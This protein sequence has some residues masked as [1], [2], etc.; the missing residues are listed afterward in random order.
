MKKNILRVVV[1][2]L[3]IGTFY[4][5]FG[6]SGQ[7]GDQSGALS[8]QITEYIAKNIKTIQNMNND[9]KEKV[10]KK[11][12]YYVR[13]LAHFSLYAIVGILIMT[14]LFTYKL[15]QRTRIISCLT[16]GTIYAI[17]DE[18]HQS[19]IPGRTPMVGDVM[20][21]MCGVLAGIVIVSFIWKINK[22]AKK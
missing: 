12:E 4:I 20:I 6:F 1:F 15:R 16:I 5:I 17:S 13:K 21:D 7:N 22:L 9:Q 2:I 3:L 18:I 19:F 10:L 14:L 11:M 8:R